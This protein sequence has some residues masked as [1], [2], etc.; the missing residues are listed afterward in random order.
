MQD[1]SLV[2]KPVPATDTVVPIWAEVGLKV[3]DGV[4]VLVAKLSVAD[5]ES[6]SG[7][8][9][10]VIAYEVGA[11]FATVNEPVKTPSEIEQV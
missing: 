11:T 10:A 5:V 7:V 6:S 9:V 1:V 4:E 3:T 8:P 2:E